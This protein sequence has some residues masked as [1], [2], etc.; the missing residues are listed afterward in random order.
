MDR[1]P[2]LANARPAQIFAAVMLLTALDDWPYGCYTVLRLAVCL[3]AA[4]LAWQSF[5]TKWP[6]WGFAMTAL[7]FLFYPVV[8]I[9]FHRHQWACI[10]VL[11][12]VAFLACPPAR[13]N[14]VS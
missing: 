7:A 9:H 5:Q 3:A 13:P 14:V 4:V 2:A 6:A 1:W 8:L 11:A 10:D 12:A